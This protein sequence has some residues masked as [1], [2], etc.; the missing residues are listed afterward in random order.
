M[1]DKA[2]QES[3]ER[4]TSALVSL[5]YTPPRRKTIVSLAPASLKK[6]GSLYDLPITLAYLIASQ[7][8]KP[9]TLLSVIQKGVQNVYIPSANASEVAAVADRLNIY[10]LDSLQQ[11]LSHLTATLD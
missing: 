8:I 4:L 2:I 6:E 7:Q 11:L 10:P 5:N 3:K 1:T 9:T